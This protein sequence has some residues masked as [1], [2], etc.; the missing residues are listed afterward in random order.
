MEYIVLFFITLRD[1]VIVHRKPQEGWY[2]ELPN[3][4]GFYTNP[5]YQIFFQTEEAA[6]AAGDPIGERVKSIK[7][8]ADWYRRVTAATATKNPEYL[9]KVAFPENGAYVD[10][11]EFGAR[12]LYISYLLDNMT[13]RI[14]K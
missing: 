9:K 14:E 12:K 1:A 11:K 3:G 7:I 8:D 2:A 4:K 6:H 13:R 5:K 10:S